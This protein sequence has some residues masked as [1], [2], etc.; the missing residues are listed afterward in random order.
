[1]RSP[2]SAPRW[3]STPLSSGS[4]TG[5][6]GSSVL[7]RHREA[8]REVAAR[9]APRAGRRAARD[10]ARAA[11]QALRWPMRR[12][13]TAT[14]NGRLGE[15]QQTPPRNGG[16][17]DVLPCGA[18]LPHARRLHPAHRLR[19]ARLVRR[20]AQGHAAAPRS[21]HRPGRS[22]P[23]DRTPATSR[24]RASS[25]PAPRRPSRRH[26]AP[27][28]GRS[29]RR[30]R[31]AACSRST[32]RRLARQIFVAPDNGLLTP[33]P[34]PAPWCT[35]V[36]RPDLY[37]EAPG[38]DLPRPRPFRADRRG[39]PARRAARRASD[40]A[41]TT[42]SARPRAAA[43]DAARGDSAGHVVH[44][45]RYGNL[46]TDLPAVVAARH[47][48][49]RR[50]SATPRCTASRPT[51]RRSKPGA[52]ALSW[53]GSLGTLEIAMRDQSAARPSPR[54]E[55]ITAARRRQSIDR[56]SQV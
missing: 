9:R 1:M 44:V 14:G 4:R 26:A 21:G 42:R 18:I 55:V 45:D 50:G 41:S 17:L 46:I 35:P 33:V 7:E 37:L 22:H 56:S 19:L 20:R 6:S 11:E 40:R 39:D 29:R 8:H 3:R 30:Q 15:D 24:P 16:L 48:D 47:S 12:V 32:R 5:G 53:S 43:R 34:R 2:R 28:G 25:S 51:T 31:R 36:D 38:A 10:A 49:L 54:D 23:R 52:A 13:L 27:R